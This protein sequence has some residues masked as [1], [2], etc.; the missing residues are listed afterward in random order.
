MIQKQET[1]KNKP[2]E[3]KKAAIQDLPEPKKELKEEQAKKVKGGAV[4]SF[5]RFEFEARSVPKT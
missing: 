1:H 4:D 3:E 5:I 2:A